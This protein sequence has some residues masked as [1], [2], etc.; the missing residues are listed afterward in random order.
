MLIA[1]QVVL[2]RTEHLHLPDE[3][4]RKINGVIDRVDA[5]RNIYPVGAPP[6]ATFWREGAGD[7]TVLCHGGKALIVSIVGWYL[8]SESVW[9]TSTGTYNRA[10]VSVK[11]LRPKDIDAARRLLQRYS[12]STEGMAVI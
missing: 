10:Y 8:A 2:S 12:T 4:V 5:S 1:I 9:T 3:V 11:P 6:V 7:T